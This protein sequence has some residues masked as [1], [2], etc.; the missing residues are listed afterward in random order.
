MKAAT[1]L[2]EA[3]EVMLASPFFAASPL[4]RHWHVR[5]G[6]TEEEVAA[7]MPGD[8]VVPEPSFGATRAI[9]IAAAPSAVWPWIVQAGFGR[10]GFYSYDLLDNAARPSAEQILAEHQNPQVGD[11]VPMAAKVGDTT[12]FRVAA[13]EPGRVLLWQKPGSTWAWSLTPVG[14]GGRTRLVTRLKAMYPWRSSPALAL[15]TLIL[16]EHGDFPMM[17]KMLIGIRARAERE[18]RRA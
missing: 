9:T 17:R 4:L 10:A 12:A 5:W 3:G 6:A 13:V 16:F 1:V 7:P 2:R 15:L 8:D 14:D 18:A 11:W